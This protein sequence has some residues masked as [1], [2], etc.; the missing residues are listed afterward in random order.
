MSAFDAIFL[1]FNLVS[2]IAFFFLA[3]ALCLR[4]YR[5]IRKRLVESTPGKKKRE[6]TA[7]I[8]VG[9]WLVVGLMI[10]FMSCS[11]SGM[12]GRG[13]ILCECHGFQI[14][15]DPEGMV[16]GA[17]YLCLGLHEEDGALAPLGK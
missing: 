11:S 14:P 5:I 8:I 1:L 13:G 3:W 2:I 16:G 12:P 15:L 17:H 7:L 9:L 4:L 10:N 6:K